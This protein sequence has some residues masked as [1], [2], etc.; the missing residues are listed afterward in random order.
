MSNIHFSPTDDIRLILSQL[1]LP[2][3]CLCCSGSSPSPSSPPLSAHDGGELE[4]LFAPPGGDDAD[5]W[6]L[7]D[8]GAMLRTPREVNRRMRSTSRSRYGYD[9]PP[10]Y[11]QTCVSSIK[12]SRK[13]LV[14]TNDDS[15]PGPLR[16]TSG[17][18]MG[19][20]AVPL[21]RSTLA[22]LP[23][24][25]RLYEPTLTLADIEREEAEQAERDRQAELPSGGERKA[26]EDEFGDFAKAGE[27]ED[28]EEVAEV[29]FG[30]EE[31]DDEGD[32]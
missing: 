29:S 4:N 5:D 1:P 8:Q 16:D 32:Q 25:A 28:E 3:F 15:E 22:N 2:S 31:S 10:A 24:L 19:P 18:D 21:E 23:N 11:D 30:L 6:S 20:N 13:S 14:A 7:E 12:Q 17:Y 27:V 9:D 26:E